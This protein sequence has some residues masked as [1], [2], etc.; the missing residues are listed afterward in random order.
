ML[1]IETTNPIHFQ[2]DIQITHYDNILPYCIGLA[3]PE[4]LL[5]RKSPDRMFYFAAC[6]SKSCVERDYSLISLVLA[7]VMLVNMSCIKILN[8]VSFVYDTM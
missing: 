2:L 4:V 8:K 3:L 5:Y 7:M 1:T 6:H